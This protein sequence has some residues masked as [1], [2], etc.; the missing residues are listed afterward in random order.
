MGIKRYF[1]DKNNTI[2]NAYQTNLVTRG[3]SSNAGL[4]DSLE[5]FSIYAQASSSSYEEAK[6]LAQFPVTS[7]VLPNV[8]TISADRTSGKIPAS[9]SVDF[10]LRLFNVVTDQTLARNFTLI[11]SPV[12]Q[13][14]EE[15]SGVDL[16]DHTD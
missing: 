16:D 13:S 6:I 3:T 1:A 12:S 14:W 8:T 9:G 15:G 10:Y 11:A 2:T 7:S 5:V 4:A